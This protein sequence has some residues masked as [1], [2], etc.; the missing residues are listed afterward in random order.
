MLISRRKQQHHWFK[1]ITGL[2]IFPEITPPWCFNSW[3]VADLQQY[4]Y[5]TFITLWSFAKLSSKRNM[6]F[7]KTLLISFQWWTKESILHLINLIISCT[8]LEGKSKQT[9][10]NK[11]KN[12]KKR[13]LKI[14]LSWKIHF[15]QQ[16]RVI[17]I[18]PRRKRNVTP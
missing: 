10:Q 6:S 11:A 7:T 8:L 15:K 12:D 17:A 1:K 16:L 18:L 4:F 5:Q 9:K 2:K 3:H 14:I 13:N